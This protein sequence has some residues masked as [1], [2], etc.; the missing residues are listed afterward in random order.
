M[1]KSIHPV[2]ALV[3]AAILAGVLLL[4]WSW[5]TEP[6]EYR[7]VEIAGFVGNTPFGDWEVTGAADVPNV[8]KVLNR[9]RDEGWSIDRILYV[10][11][12]LLVVA[13]R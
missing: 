10:G 7:T 9:L 3:V 12:S 13:A 2:L 5:W 11:E 8:T 4:L 6:R 1:S